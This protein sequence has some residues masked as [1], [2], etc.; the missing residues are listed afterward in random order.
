MQNDGDPDNDPL[1]LTGVSAASARGGTVQVL[2]T[3]IIYRSLP[4]DRAPDSFTYTIADGRNGLATATVHLTVPPDI[5]PAQN[6]LCGPTLVGGQWQVTFAGIP[7]RTYMVEF[8]TDLQN[9]S[10]L[11]TLTVG[12]DGVGTFTDPNPPG[13][14]RF[15]RLLLP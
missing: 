12:G 2:G 11:G 6:I 9:W 13:A 8:S 15:Y 10:P 1:T 5:R 4:G 3:W 14:A 7:G